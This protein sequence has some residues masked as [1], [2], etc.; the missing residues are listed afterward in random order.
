[1]FAKKFVP[2]TAI[3]PGWVSGGR[4]LSKLGHDEE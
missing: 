4:W 2:N 1:M 3:I